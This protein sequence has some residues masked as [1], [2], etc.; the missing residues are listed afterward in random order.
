[1]GKAKKKKLKK[2][3]GGLL[4]FPFSFFFGLQKGGKG[5]RDDPSGVAWAREERKVGRKGNQGEGEIRA[6][7]RGGMTSDVKV[8]S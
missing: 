1:M 6:R 3:R 4:F 2:D 8:S 7:I 5:K